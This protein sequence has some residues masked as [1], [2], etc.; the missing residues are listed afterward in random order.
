MKSSNTIHDK[1]ILLERISELIFSMTKAGN[2]VLII[3]P[4]RY[5][6]TAVIKG[7]NY[8]GTVPEGE[9]VVKRHLHN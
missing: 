4:C 9:K 3:G 1:N 2:P 5:D 8:A 6:L 7:P